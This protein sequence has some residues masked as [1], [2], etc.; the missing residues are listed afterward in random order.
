M[1]VNYV[2]LLEKYIKS[3]QQFFFMVLESLFNPIKAEKHPG[4]MFFVGLL[5]T[6]LALFLALWIF[7]DYSSLVFVFLIVMA[8]IPLI[9]N[10]IKLEEHKDLYFEE[11]KELLKEHGKAISFF[12]FLFLGVVVAVAFCY[13]FLPANMI[14]NL[15]EIQTQTIIDI[16]NTFTGNAVQQF[17]IFVHILMNN[18]KVLV[19]CLLFSFLFGAGAIFIL[20]WNASV[21]GVAIGNY[22]R[23]N[24]VYVTQN[25]GLTT[26]T[27]YFNVFTFGLL[28][29][30]IHGIPEILAYFIVGLAGSI[31]SIAVIRH[32]FSTKKFDKILLDSSDLIIA[33]IAIIILAAFLE[34]YVTPLIF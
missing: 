31:I 33:A 12:M 21:I 10:T 19:F 20:T 29:Y 27:E 16:N 8:S 25:A 30:A 23:S 11:E 1:L 9:Y 5:Y 13:T 6:V 28:K 15:F 22:M 32:D 4:Q 34:T 18:L 14:N 26:F 3:R 2:Q 7:A 17:N 24:L